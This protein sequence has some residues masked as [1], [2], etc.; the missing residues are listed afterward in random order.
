MASYYE[1]NKE[2]VKARSK[3]RVELVRFGGMR[4]AVILRDGEKCVGCG[5]TRLQHKELWGADITVN[6]IDGT[7]RNDKDTNND[8]SNL[9]TL[10]LKCHGTKDT[11]RGDKVSRTQDPEWRAKVSKGWFQKG[12]QVPDELREANRKRML[13]ANP[14][15]GK[16][17]S[18]ETR[19][20]MSAKAKARH[21][22]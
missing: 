16:K 4:E 11:V 18:L 13:G 2:L 22:R 17:H 15:K 14:F 9:E 5:M 7:G 10:C 20:I 8:P 12:R 19:A 21:A 6:H 3:A 1:K